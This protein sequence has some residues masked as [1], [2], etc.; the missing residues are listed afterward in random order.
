MCYYASAWG[1]S[2]IPLAVPVVVNIPVRVLGL[3]SCSYSDSSSSPLQGSA[4]GSA[5]NMVGVLRTHPDNVFTGYFREQ[6]KSH[7]IH[8]AENCQVNTNIG[9]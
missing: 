5:L 9:L 6:I 7:V 3:H 1:C 2:P 4:S 8:H